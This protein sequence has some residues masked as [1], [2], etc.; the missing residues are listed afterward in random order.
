VG[1]QEHFYQSVQ[2][3]ERYGGQ[4]DGY[5]FQSHFGYGLTSITRVFDI[6]DRY[7]STGKMIK[8]TEFDVVVED[9][10]LQADY[11][12]DFLTITFSHPAV[13]G[14]MNWGFW[15]KQH[16]EPS[17]AFFDGDWTIRPNGK[18]W[19]DLVFNQWWTHDTVMTDTSGVAVLSGF[20]GSYEF[21]V[22]K[23]GISLVDTLDLTSFTGANLQVVLAPEGHMNI[24]NEAIP[25][26]IIYFKKYVWDVEVP[27]IV[28]F[29]PEEIIPEHSEM[30]YSNG[31]IHLYPNPFSDYL[32]IENEN[33]EDFIHY[34]IT[35]LTGRVFISDVYPEDKLIRGLSNLKSGVYLIQ[36]RSAGETATKRIVKR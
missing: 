8:I 31:S 18:E 26:S 11:L 13:A 17:A 30:I 35:D 21:T 4:V 9:Q 7:A 16:W 12:R 10:E 24:V 32:I 28:P 25:D 20:L 15:E 19:I 14:F 2:Y 3:I 22:S 33:E 36:L 23:E 5:G 6:L 29:V 34:S 27:D 1:H